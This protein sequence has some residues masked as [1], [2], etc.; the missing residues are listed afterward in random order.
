LDRV[1]IHFSSASVTACMHDKRPALQL[2]IPESLT[3]IQRREY[4]RVDAPVTNPPRC[5][6]FVERNEERRAVTLELKDISAGG[7]AVLD[8][9]RVLDAG[10]G[11]IY[12]GCRLELPDVDVI[13]VDLK[14][15]QCLDEIL[16]NGKERRL[17]GCGFFN[18][19]N[20]Q[21]IKVQ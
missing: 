11:T 8:N 12:M 6:F 7:I 2:P 19:P 16:P 3:R 10:K 17:L 9:G 20:P 21:M 14:V 13:D 4:Y 1:K 5:T 18:L 15:A